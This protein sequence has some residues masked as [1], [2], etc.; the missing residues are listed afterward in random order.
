MVILPTAFICSL[1]QD[2]SLSKAEWEELYRQAWVRYYTPEHMKT[3]MRRA[4]ATKSNPGNMVML[5][6][7]YYLCFML[8]GVDPL[9]GGYFRRKYR[10]ERRPAFPLENP[11][12]FYSRYFSDIVR[13][14]LKIIGMILRFGRFRCQLKRDPEARSYSDSALADVDVEEDEIR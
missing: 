14:H 2:L 5:L 11:L 4:V 8:E 7:W 1:F 3:I 9:Q 10:K 6:C 13:K 12:L